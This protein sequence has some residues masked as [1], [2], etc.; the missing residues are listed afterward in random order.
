MDVLLLESP[1]DMIVMCSN[2]MYDVYWDGLVSNQKGAFLKG[3]YPD[4]VIWS[5]AVDAFASLESNKAVMDQLCSQGVD[6]IKLYPTRV[7]TENFQSERWFMDD[8][9]V[10]FPLF[11]YAHFKGIRNI[12]THMLVDYSPG[13][14]PAPKDTGFIFTD[15]AKAKI[16]GLN[17]A[18]CHGID[19]AA[20]RAKMADDKFTRYKAVH[21]HRES[22]I[23]QREAA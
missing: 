1:T 21:G 8:E 11:E 12:A 9:R 14:Y 3:K 4:C 19:V 18:R 20:R 15:G 22:Y 16:L 6:G 13:K 5:G 7:N 2:P 17:L 10:A 23:A